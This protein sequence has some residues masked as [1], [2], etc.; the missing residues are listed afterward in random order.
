MKKLL[1]L[2]LVLGSLYSCGS[3]KVKGSRNVT[4]ERTNLKDFTSVEIQGDFEVGLKKGN[5][6]HMEVEAD[7][8][9]HSLIQTDIV[10]NTLFIKSRK[11]VKSSK[12]FE[13]ILSF[14]EGLDRILITDNVEL[15]SEEDLY[16]QD[17][18]VH[19]NG[20]AKAFLTLTARDFNLYKNDKSKTELNLTASN[21]YFQ[22][23]NSSDLEALVYSPI[24]KADLYEKASAKIEG[25]T[26]EFEL[27]SE[28]S[29][30]FKGSKLTAEN[31]VVTAEGR[32]KNEVQVTGKLKLT[33]KDRSQVKVYGD[34]AIE[35][36][37]FTEKAELKKKE[38]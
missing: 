31:A 35:L 27:R 13:I 34:P 16:L 7:D 30:N 4:T 2:F 17:V 11:P 1:L 3:Q 5:R 22:L 33:A 12:S 29:T 8:N 20:K 24:F 32:S 15:Y 37:E 36:V 19:I 26:G 18:E 10:D 28:H 21:T 9:L 23:N 25:E 14:P 6:A 38:H